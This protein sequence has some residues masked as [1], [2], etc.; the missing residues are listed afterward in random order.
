LPAGTI[1]ENNVVIPLP[2]IKFIK[3][4]VGIKGRSGIPKNTRQPY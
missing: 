4:I 3:R 2:P 1:V